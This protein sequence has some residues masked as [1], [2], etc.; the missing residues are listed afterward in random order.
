[1]QQCAARS[2]RRAPVQFCRWRQVCCDNLKACAAPVRINC[3]VKPASLKPE[4][5][6]GPIRPAL[7]RLAPAERRRRSRP[8]G[9]SI[10]RRMARRRRRPLGSFRQARHPACNESGGSA[11]RVHAQPSSVRT[12]RPQHEPFAADSCIESLPAQPPEPPDVRVG[13]AQAPPAVL[14]PSCPPVG[15]AKELHAPGGC[16]VE[17][18]QTPWGAPGCGRAAPCSAWGFAQNSCSPRRPNYPAPRG[19]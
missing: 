16:V 2:G 14:A 13:E 11:R 18:M 10:S 9:N 7:P 3:R 1:M 12:G 8:A 6:C 4:S 19:L 15:P 17:P 5:R